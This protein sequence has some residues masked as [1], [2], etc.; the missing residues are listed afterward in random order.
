M[1]SDYLEG[2]GIISREKLLHQDRKET[3]RIKPKIDYN[4]IKI[5]LEKSQIS[6]SLEHQSLLRTGK[7]SLFEACHTFGLYLISGE[8]PNNQ[9]DKTQYIYFFG[10]NINEISEFAKELREI[11]PDSFEEVISDN[12]LILMI[13]LCAK[14]SYFRKVSSI[15]STNWLPICAFYCPPLEGVNYTFKVSQSDTVSAAFKLN[16]KGVAG[17]KNFENIIEVSDTQNISGVSKYLMK[18]LLV[19]CECVSDTWSSTQTNKII[20]TLHIQEIK[21]ERR[22]RSHHPDVPIASFDDITNMELPKDLETLHLDSRN[23]SG[24]KSV[25]TLKITKCREHIF[26]CDFKGA[27]DFLSAVRLF[28][29]EIK[30]KNETALTL[31]REL[32]EGYSYAFYPV[33]DSSHVYF[34][35]FTTNT[36]E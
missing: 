7:I 24:K 23:S 13:K 16:V 3:V 10:S 12:F 29:V 22:W 4:Q 36:L 30:S 21:N 31:D 34:T 18:T 5:L 25:T 33:K 1:T 17:G 20:T 32:E 14:L 11:D 19:N 15:N 2:L 8:P 28:S 35:A 27:P 9:F 6:P 26:S